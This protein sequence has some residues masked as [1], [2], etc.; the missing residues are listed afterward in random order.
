MLSNLNGMATQSSLLPHKI[1]V[2]STALVGN[3][4]AALAFV[5]CNQ[6]AKQFLPVVMLGF[7]HHF[8]AV[9]PRQKRPLSALDAD[10]WY[11]SLW[12]RTRLGLGFVLV[13]PMLWT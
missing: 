7:P 12:L 3:T 9:W 11:E 2:S 4:H 8:L 1:D 5:G 13:L 10:Q 6:H